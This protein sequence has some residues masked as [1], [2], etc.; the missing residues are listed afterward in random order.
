MGNCLKGDS[1]QQPVRSKNANTSQATYQVSDQDKTILKLKAFRDKLLSQ[2]R[3]L[4]QN[5][6]KAQNEAKTLIKQ[7]KKDR[8]LFA[9]KRKKLYDNM[10][11]DIENQYTI[12]EKT[13]IDVEGKIQ[14]AEATNVLKETNDL[15][16]QLDTAVKLE[17]LQQ[18][19]EDVRQREM[20]T[21]EFNKLFEEHNVNDSEINDLFRQFEAEVDAEGAAVGQVQQK[22]V[23]KQQS[24]A[25][26]EVY[27]PQH[28]EE[29]G[30]VEVSQKLAMLA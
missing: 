11:T 25:R 1:V 3:A 4:Y 30:D 27:R 16:K 10:V 28:Q 2:K 20:E 24:P 18:I 7:G 26:Q 6:D 17:E 22:S 19:G 15:L 9:L 8:A 29:E 5:S 12:V 13:V 23:V 14:L 21:R